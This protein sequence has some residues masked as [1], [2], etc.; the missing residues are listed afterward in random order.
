MSSDSKTP[1]TNTAL[2]GEFSCDHKEQCWEPCG[3]LGKSEQHAKPTTQ[4][5]PTLVSIKP[6]QE[7]PTING[8]SPSHGHVRPRPDGMKARCGGP[9]VCKVC[10]AEKDTVDKQFSVQRY[11]GSLSRAARKRFLDT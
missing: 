10:K 6:H 2:M 9:T 1:C 4:A 11:Y 3:D 8:I 7:S 5:T